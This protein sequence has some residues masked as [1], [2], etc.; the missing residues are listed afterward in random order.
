LPSADTRAA[1][2]SQGS[3]SFP[4]GGSAAAKP[5]AWGAVLVARQF[6]DAGQQRMASDLGMWVFLAT[7]VLFFGA[8]FAAYTATRLH[9]PQ[10]FAIASRLTNVTLGSINTGV[11]L[12]S[13]LMMALAVRATKLGLRRT[14]IRFLWAT[15]ALGVVFLAIKFTEYY[16][17]YT[18]H[19]V[20]ALDFSHAGPHAGGVENFFYLYFF[21][22]GV[23][24]LHMVIGIA[25]VS[26]LAVMASRRRYTPEYFTPV[27]LGG[28]YWHLVDVVWI[29][30]YPL[31]YLVSRT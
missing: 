11:L 6:D 1:G 4:Y 26:V 14:S 9:D 25:I 24:S 22:T 7:E 15:A 18:G 20:P 28:L 19:L 2:P 30:L 27:E 10:A 23:H 5:Q 12:T 17:D 8:L 13:S 16:L 29:F 3:S 21:M 31:L